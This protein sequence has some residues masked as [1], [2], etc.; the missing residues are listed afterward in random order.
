LNKKLLV[1]A[2]AIAGLASLATAAPITCGFDNIAN[3]TGV[4]A[5]IGCPTIG[6]GVNAITSITLFLSSDYTGYKSGTPV[7]TLTYAINGPVSFPAVAPQI[8][9]T[10]PGTPPNSMPVMITLMGNLGLSSISG[11]SVT[12]TSSI[13]GGQVVASS[14]VVRIDYSTSVTPEPAALG[15]MGAGL[16]GIGLVSRRLKRS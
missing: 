10:I 7:V 1:L 9:N 6:D 2:V 11:I 3:G 13:T 4:G 14:A 15:L 5:A 8:V 12:P 16:L